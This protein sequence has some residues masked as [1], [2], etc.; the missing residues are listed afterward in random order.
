[1]IWGWDDLELE[2]RLQALEVVESKRRD[3]LVAIARVFHPLADWAWYIVGGDIDPDD[4]D[5]EFYGLVFSPYEPDGVMGYFTLSQME[6]MPLIVD[7]KFKPT[8]IPELA[9]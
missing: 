6:E 3:N 9:P 1:M 5:I 7:S 4:G 2:G 8:P